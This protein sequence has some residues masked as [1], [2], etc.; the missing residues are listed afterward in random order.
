M[1]VSGTTVGQIVTYTCNSGYE[2]MGNSTRTCQSSG[3]WTGSQPSCSG[4]LY[5]SF[6]V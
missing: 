6:S 1:S 4:K 2:L 3:Q 5:M